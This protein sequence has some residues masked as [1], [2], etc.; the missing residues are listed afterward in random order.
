[1]DPGSKRLLLVLGL[2]S[3]SNSMDRIIFSVLV[4]PIKLGI[5]KVFS[6]AFPM[7]RLCEA[8]HKSRAGKITELGDFDIRK[9][10]PQLRFALYDG[11]R[12]T[13]FQSCITESHFV[14]FLSDRI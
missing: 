2:V 6:C 1:M 7:S 13:S 5:G 14:S 8:I 4:E 9:I 12:D 3:L 10:H 11:Q